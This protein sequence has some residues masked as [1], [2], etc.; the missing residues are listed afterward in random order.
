[1]TTVTLIL[2]IL[3]AA[4]LYITSLDYEPYIKLLVEAY[5][6]LEGDEAQH[7]FEV[8]EIMSTR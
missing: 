5:A 6:N 8:G 7:Y 3:I 2:W 4:L 1:M